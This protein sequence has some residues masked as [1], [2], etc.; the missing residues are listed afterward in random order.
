MNKLKRVSPLAMTV[1]QLR[2]IFFMFV[3]SFFLFFF[4]QPQSMVWR[5]CTGAAAIGF[6]FVSLL[7]LP[8]KY[9]KLAYQ[10]EGDILYLRWGVVY[11]RFGA[12]FLE[13]VQYVTVSATPVQRIFH[14]CSV[15]FILAGGRMTIPCIPVEE[16]KMLRLWGCSQNGEGRA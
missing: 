15:S 10:L 13:N 6:V 14:L 8:V 3:P 11:T 16:G 1:W 12:A 5:L 4:Y 2:L 9:M 7:W